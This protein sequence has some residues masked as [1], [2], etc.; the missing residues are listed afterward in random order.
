[1]KLLDPLVTV[2]IDQGDV[3]ETEKVLDI[4]GLSG[5]PQRMLNLRSNYEQA[6]QRKKRWVMNTH[7]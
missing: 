6:S 4:Q 7:P 2:P 3:S 1:M 5:G